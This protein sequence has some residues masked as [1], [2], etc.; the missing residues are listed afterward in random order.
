METIDSTTQQKEFLP[1]AGSA[2]TL[3][4]WGNA[5]SLL[6]AIPF[7]GVLGCIAGIILSIMG[8]KKGRA[9]MDEWKANKPKY[10]GGS[11]AK[12]LIAYILG[13]VGIVQGAILAIYS[14]VFSVI[15]LDGGFDRMFR[16][17]F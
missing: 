14:V 4:I 10:H 17:M 5:I 3:S 1:E 7:L 6:Y 15:I 13:I 16:H 9:G 11:F 2:L 12:T 8:L